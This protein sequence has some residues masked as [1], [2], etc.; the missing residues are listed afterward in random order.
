[1]VRRDSNLENCLAALD[2][3]AVF[4]I[5]RIYAYTVHKGSVCGTEV[6]KECLGRGNLDD[7][8]MTREETVVRKAEM[9]VLASA[10]HECVVLIESKRSSRLRPGHNIKSYTHQ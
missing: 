7:A 4:Q 9:R 10:D 3:I 6:A 8:M 1:M 5:R 2:S